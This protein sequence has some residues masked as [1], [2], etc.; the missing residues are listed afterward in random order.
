MESYDKETIAIIN[1][2]W[3]YALT[4]VDLMT[5]KCLAKDKSTQMRMVNQIKLEN[6]LVLRL[7][8]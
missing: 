3:N 8:F 6:I 7:K 4:K 2:Q 5:T 1:S